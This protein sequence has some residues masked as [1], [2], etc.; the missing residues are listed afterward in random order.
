[1]RLPYQVHLPIGA[2]AALYRRSRP[3][4]VIP[5]ESMATNPTCISIDTK[6]HHATALENYQ[7]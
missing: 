7:C 5:G 6:F 1:M 2:T 4:P 3:L